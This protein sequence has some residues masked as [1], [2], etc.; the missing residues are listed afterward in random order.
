MNKIKPPLEQNNPGPGTYQSKRKTIGT[1]GSKPAFAVSKTIKCKNLFKP[2]IESPGPAAYD[3]NIYQR[4]FYYSRQGGS[5]HTKSST[6]KVE[7]FDSS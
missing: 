5:I 2:T 7:R 1:E 6:N 4:R 3:L